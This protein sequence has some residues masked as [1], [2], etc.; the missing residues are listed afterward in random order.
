M[1]LRKTIDKLL[2]GTIR[3]P[4]FQRSYVWEPNRAAVLMDSIYKGYPVG[5]L[6]LWRS[7]HRLRTERRLGAF[8]LP[9][10]DADYP[11]DYVL[12]GQQR[13][14]SIFATF[15][16]TLP[17]SEPDPDVWLPIY[18]DFR[19][20]EDAQESRFVALQDAE[21]D[22][23]RHFPLG[24]FFEP[25]AFSRVTR[26]LSTER[27]EEIVKVQQRFLEALVSV[28]TFETEDRTSVAIVFERVIAWASSST[29][30]S[31]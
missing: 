22:S 27:H 28:E 10:P 30:S 14:T 29:F 24:V 1:S 19:A 5:S 15:Q 25:V 3:I 6:L 11:V 21:V 8:E 20:E 12:D 9:P 31:S 23:A 16:T 18:Y 2:D 26:D 4:G 7:R 13:L 17:A